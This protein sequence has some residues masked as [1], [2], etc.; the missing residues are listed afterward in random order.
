M[1]PALRSIRCEAENRCVPSRWVCD[2]SRDCADGSDERDCHLT[3]GKALKHPFHRADEV[4][5]FRT[6]PLL[7][8]RLWQQISS[9]LIKN[10]HN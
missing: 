3:Q 4:K 7:F 5:F 6:L 9:R 8:L 1:I 10:F 2:G